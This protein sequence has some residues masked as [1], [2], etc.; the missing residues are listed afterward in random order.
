MGNLA[1]ILVRHADDGAFEHAR[2]LGH[3]VLYLGRVDVETRDQD[4]ILLAIDDFHEA[5]LI[6]AAEVAV[7]EGAIGRRRS[8]RGGS[9]SLASPVARLRSFA[10]LA[11]LARC[12]PPCPGG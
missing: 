7:L 9:N 5:A 4:H 3:Y 12:E 8:Q 1:Q 11:Y 6:H 10:D 2:Q